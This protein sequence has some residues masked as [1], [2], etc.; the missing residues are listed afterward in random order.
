LL[1]LL[2][3]SALAGRFCGL[4]AA[5]NFVKTQRTAGQVVFFSRILKGMFDAD[6]DPRS[7]QTDQPKTD[8]GQKGMMR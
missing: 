5:A 6:L 8:N 2:G 4:A 7:A 3:C 1:L